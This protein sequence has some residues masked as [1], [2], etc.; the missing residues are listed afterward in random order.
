VA[1]PHARD[2]D[3]ILAK[4]H[5]NGADYWATPDGRVYVGNPYST[6]SCLNMLHELEVTESHEAVR[7]ALDI[8]L[9]AWREDGRFRLAPKAPLYPCYTAEAARALCRYGYGHDERLQLTAAYLLDDAHETGGWRCNFTK[10]GKGPETQWANPAATLYVLDVLRFTGH[11]DAGAVIDEAVES[12]LKHWETRAPCG[13]C[14]Y[15]IGTTF[16]QAEYPFLRYNLFYYVYVLSFYEAARGDSRFREA[17]SLLAQHV[18][19]E[20]RVVV[21]QRHRG[22]KGL[23]FCERGEPSDSATRRYRE[24]SANLEH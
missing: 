12:L 1:S 8:V 10:F 17:A 3:T 6:L 18:D 11:R 20:G 5:H 9:D 16:L 24:I 14:R 4:R 23:A 13:P 21:A 19:D 15:G 22:L 7:G 2:I